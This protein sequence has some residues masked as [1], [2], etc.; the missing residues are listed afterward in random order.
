MF[1][2]HYPD[3]RRAH[4]FVILNERV[5]KTA[6]NLIFLCDIPFNQHGYYKSFDH[7]KYSLTENFI[8]RE[9]KRERETKNNLS[10]PWHIQHNCCVR[11]ASE[12]DGQNE[13]GCIEL[14]A[15]KPENFYW[16]TQI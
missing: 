7:E 4:T 14:V 13:H 3:I 12:R 10:M 8:N 6:Q 15:Q 2:Y 9:T 11:L 16:H 1:I 5:K